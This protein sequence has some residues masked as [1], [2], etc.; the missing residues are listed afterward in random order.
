MNRVKSSRCI[1]CVSTHVAP[2]RGF[3][4][5][6]TSFRTFIDYLSENKINYSLVCTDPDEAKIRKGRYFIERAYKSWG[7]AEYGLSIKAFF[8]IFLSV[9]IRKRAVVIVNGITTPINFVGIL[10]TVYRNAYV[11]IF[12]R[13]SFEKGRT[14]KW[15]YIKKLYYDLN[16]YL[17]HNLD[18]KNNLLIVYQTSEEKLRSQEFNFQ[19]SIVCGNILKESFNH[20]CMELSIRQYDLAFVGRNSYEKGI[21]RLISFS[22][23][24]KHS[25]KKLNIV[26][27]F[28]GLT[29][30]LFDILKKNLSAHNVKIYQNLQNNEVL[31]FLSKTRFFYFPSYIENFGNTLVES[32]SA[33]CVP[34]V[35]PD[36]H[37][38]EL[39]KLNLAI[40][41]HDFLKYMDLGFDY[42]FFGGMS[43]NLKLYVIDNYIK[44]KDF[45][46][47]LKHI[48]QLSI[49]KNNHV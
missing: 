33:G 7:R 12:A 25:K 42:D 1:Y 14:D 27:I 15:S 46:L 29:S 19:N 9:N 36:T 6:S 31:T 3:G 44:D 2:T 43:A 40:S 17:L 23:S 35:F 45:S 37:W 5:P 22:E 18:K 30:E 34:I 39:V 13:G 20:S 26:L 28:E 16:I 38:S 8:R 10:S 49:Q 41:E 11:I 21:D 47:I 4:G 32:V 48:N 24:V